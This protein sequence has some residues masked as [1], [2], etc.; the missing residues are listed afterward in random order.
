MR[1][2]FLERDSD[3]YFFRSILRQT[4][5]YRESP[6]GNPFER[7]IRCWKTLPLV[8]LKMDF[9]TALF[10]CTRKG[11]LISFQRTLLIVVQRQTNAT[12]QLG[13]FFSHFRL[14]RRSLS[15]EKRQNHCPSRAAGASLRFCGEGKRGWSKLPYVSSRH[16]RFTS[17]NPGAQWPRIDQPLDPVGFSGGGPRKVN[18]LL[19]PSGKNAGKFERT[20]NGTNSKQDTPVSWDCFR[21]VVS[22]DIFLS[23]GP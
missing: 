17:S 3:V 21:S 22:V 2:P 20:T 23:K 16:G 13:P 14:W 4:A 5:L 11:R 9:P 8:S 7:R 12:V 1:I 18:A 6:L 15:G 19:V 10:S